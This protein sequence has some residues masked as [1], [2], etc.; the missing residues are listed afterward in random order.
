MA[1][2]AGGA[3]RLPRTVML[4]L[5]VIAGIVVA[6]LCLK[7]YLPRAF[8]Q[9]AALA[10][11]DPDMIFKQ[12]GEQLLAN[13]GRLPEETLERVSMAVRD[14]PLASEPFVLFAMKALSENDLVRAERLLVEARAR[15]PRNRLARLALIGTYLQTNRVREGSGEVA[16]LVRIMPRANELLVPQLAQLAFSPRTGA[17]VVEAVGDQPIMADVLDR[18]VQQNAPPDLLLRLAARQPQPVNGN[19]APWQTNL[20]AR[21][22]DRGQAARAQELWRRF[23]GAGENSGLVYDPEFRGLP[24]PPPFNWQLTVS[25]VGAAELAAGPSLELEYFGRK[26]GPLA[27]QLLMLPPGR[28]S[29]EAQVQGSANGQGSRI[30]MQVTCSEGAALFNL[31][32]QGQFQTPKTIGGN[33]FVP[34]RGCGSQWLTFAG[35]AAEFPNSQRARITGLSLRSGGGSR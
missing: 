1:S 26:S 11:E 7:T 27:R 13:E 28:Y 21:L 24:G 6:W 18:M 29:L 10:A 8:P 15:N 34:A 20:L 16:A 30:V 4:G 12:A 3:R 19:F 35:E 33:F 32:L 25:D 2:T 22:V 14:A 5:L 23:V 9:A 31:P 17:A